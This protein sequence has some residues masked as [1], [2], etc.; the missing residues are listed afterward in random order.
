MGSKEKKPRKLLQKHHE[1]SLMSLSRKSRSMPVQSGTFA[2][3]KPQTVIGAM[4]I[5]IAL[6]YSLLGYTETMVPVCV[7]AIIGPG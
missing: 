7:V 1:D 4:G 5:L 6:V 3:L 2:W